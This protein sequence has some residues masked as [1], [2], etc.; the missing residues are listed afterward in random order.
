MDRGK[1]GSR[2][3]A[4]FTF[5]QTVVSISATTLTA[6]GKAKGTSSGIGMYRFNDNS[7]L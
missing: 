4:A 2:M 6:T 7:Q 1:T 3:A 5:G